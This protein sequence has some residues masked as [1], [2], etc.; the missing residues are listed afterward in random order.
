M[1]SSFHISVIFVFAGI[2]FLEH[3]SFGRAPL[4]RRTGSQER[5]RRLIKTH[6][7]KQVL[8]SQYV[9]VRRRDE[10]K[11]PRCLIIQALY[12]R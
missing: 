10:S 12:L 1:V 9:T 5:K 3:Q 4:A 6:S 2:I 11:I 8:Q 7:L